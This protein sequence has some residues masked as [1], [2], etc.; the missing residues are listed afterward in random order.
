MQVSTLFH[1]LLLLFL[2][3]LL[4]VFPFLCQAYLYYTRFIFTLCFYNLQLLKTYI[5]L[6]SD[7]KG[8][9]ML[10]DTLRHECGFRS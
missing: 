7:I 6:P 4:Y 9:Y 1:M 2:F 8:L 3:S 10:L 5:Y